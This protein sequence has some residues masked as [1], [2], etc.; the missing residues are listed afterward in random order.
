MLVNEPEQLI[1]EEDAELLVPVA[2]TVPQPPTSNAHLKR[3]TDKTLYLCSEKAKTCPLCRKRMK[4]MVSHFK[5][6]HPNDEV[7]VSRISSKMVDFIAPQNENERTF[8]RDRKHNANYIQTMCIFCEDTKI[9]MPNY[10]IDH[11]ASH[12]G[13]YG[14]VCD[15]CDK[16]CSFGKHC[17]KPATRIDN[18]NLRYEHLIAYRCNECNFVQMKIQNIRAH[19]ANQHGLYDEGEQNFQ[20]FTLLPSFCSLV[21][22]S[23]PNEQ[24]QISGKFR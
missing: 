5:T 24:E 19:L 13:E 1:E 10:W 21:R 9:F 6:Q 20:V 22:Q 16:L 12:T 3:N 11:M 4:F 2:V 17:D 7:F 14:N 18:L 23:D 8:I 15:V